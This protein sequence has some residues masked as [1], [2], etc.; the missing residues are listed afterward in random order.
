MLQLVLKDFVKTVFN[1]AFPYFLPCSS[2]TLS[3]Q[4]VNFGRMNI[5]QGK[6][7]FGGML[8]SLLHAIL[9]VQHEDW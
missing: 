7:D 6:C 3:Y 8:P 2:S 9:L 4:S 1:S 5:H